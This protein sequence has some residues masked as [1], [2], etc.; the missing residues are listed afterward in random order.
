MINNQQY[1]PDKPT[2]SQSKVFNDVKSTS[3]QFQNR[4]EREFMYSSGIFLKNSTVINRQNEQQN[5]F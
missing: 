4:N 2:L 3:G 5:Y 1:L